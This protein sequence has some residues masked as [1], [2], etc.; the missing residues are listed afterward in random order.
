MDQK[1]SESSPDGHLATPALVNFWLPVFVLPIEPGQAA[2]KIAQARLPGSRVLDTRRG[3]E[4][5][6]EGRQGPPEAVSGL[7]SAAAS[8]ASDWT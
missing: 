7:I 3:A 2:Q 5:F 8:S 6:E 1:V 4:D